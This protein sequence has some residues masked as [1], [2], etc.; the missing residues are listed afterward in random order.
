[1]EEAHMRIPAHPGRLL[2]MELK[3]RKLSAARLALEIGVPANRVTAIVK[4]ERAITPDTALRLGR[5]F[6]TGP[7]LWASMQTQHDLGA[8]RAR[9]DKEIE[10]TVRPAPA[11][12]MRVRG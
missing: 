3:A 8:A 6:G 11:Q 9:L 7:D 1:M 12:G 2:D 10:R 5:Y 4:G